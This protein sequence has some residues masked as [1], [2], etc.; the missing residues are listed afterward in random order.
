VADVDIRALIA[1]HRA[2]R[3]L[4]TVTSV[5]PPGRF[6]ALDISKGRIT[7][8]REKPQ[9]DGA[10]ISG[11]F[12]VLSPRVTD[13][14]DGDDTRW[15]VEPLERL[16]AES[17]LSAYQHDGFWQPMDTLRDKVVLDDLWASG[18]APWKVW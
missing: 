7:G 1:F 15:E 18:S 10:S 4:A 8:F 14:I 12:F 9:G 17:Q 3:T 11:G 13:Y 5:R 6:G 16:A 2:Q